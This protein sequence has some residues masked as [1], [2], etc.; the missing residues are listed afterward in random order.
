MFSHLNIDVRRD[1]INTWWQAIITID[2]VTEFDKHHCCAE[3][4][5]FLGVDAALVNHNAS[6]IKT[7][8][9]FSVYQST[10]LILKYFCVVS[11]VFYLSC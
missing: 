6:V 5:E 7:L 1:E 3:L 9:I 8:N 11:I 2:K 10:S 4:R